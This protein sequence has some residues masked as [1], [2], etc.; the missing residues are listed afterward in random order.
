MF[1]NDYDITYKDVRFYSF[2][3]LVDIKNTTE[4]F[5]IPVSLYYDG[6]DLRGDVG[7]CVS[8]GN[9]KV[10]DKFTEVAAKTLKV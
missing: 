9:S 5:K 7:I 2:V 6:S 1:S 8:P 3:Q 4:E 10:R